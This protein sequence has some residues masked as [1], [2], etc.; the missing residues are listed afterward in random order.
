FNFTFPANTVFLNSKELQFDPKGFKATKEDGTDVT[1]DIEV[2][3][4]YNGNSGSNYDKS[5]EGEYLFK[6]LFENN[7]IAEY[8]FRIVKKV[9]PRPVPTPTLRP[10]QNPSPAPIPSTPTPMPTE[11]NLAP[12]I[13]SLKLEDSQEYLIS[14]INYTSHNFIT[15]IYSKITNPIGK[16]YSD[17]GQTFEFDDSMPE[18]QWKF[19]K[20]KINIFDR[21]GTYFVEIKIRDFDGNWSEVYSKSIKLTMN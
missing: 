19:V 8:T 1:K 2:E 12:I 18:F 6:Y 20:D 21:D 5:K 4:T 9:E 16:T 10:T 17:Y 7:T 15:E 11:N 3:I 14:T 13:K